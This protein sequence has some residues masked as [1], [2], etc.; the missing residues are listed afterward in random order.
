MC[1]ESSQPLYIIIFISTFI[2]SILVH[3]YH[4]QVTTHIKQIIQGII[5]YTLAGNLLWEER[6]VQTTTADQAQEEHP[7]HQTTDLY[8]P[9]IVVCC[10]AWY[11]SDSQEKC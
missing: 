2:R 7:G 10:T 1:F 4:R 3:R 9:Y 6:Y 5:N 11:Y 8:Q